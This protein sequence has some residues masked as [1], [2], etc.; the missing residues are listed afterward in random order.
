MSY[1]WSFTYTKDSALGI[2]NMRNL[3]EK[4]QRATQWTC[5]N[6]EAGS[7]TIPVFNVSREPMHRRPQT[8]VHS[9]PG[10]PYS[11]ILYPLGYC[12]VGCGRCFI[13]AEDL[14]GSCQASP[15]IQTSTI[16]VFLQSIVG[17]FESPLAL[18]IMEKRCLILWI[19]S[20]A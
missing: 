6:H 2:A 12:L 4:G 10:T 16:V 9:A 15:S 1:D 11:S 18:L 17:G 3:Q 8:A 19:G 5:S 20:S 14:A 7:P 13:S